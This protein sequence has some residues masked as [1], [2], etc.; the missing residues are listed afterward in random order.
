MAR[1]TNCQR[2]IGQ[3]LALLALVGMT[4]PAFGQDV[5]EGDLLGDSDGVDVELPAMDAREGRILFAAK[6]CVICHSVN[7]VGGQAAPALDAYRQPSLANPFEFSARMWT[8]ASDMI[9]LQKKDLGYQI[10]IT[11]E[12]LADIFA[13]VHDADEQLLFTIPGRGG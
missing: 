7:G 3:A 11:G 8:G 5:L 4:L 1:S 12:E 10:T 13:F 6:G 9:A 2:G